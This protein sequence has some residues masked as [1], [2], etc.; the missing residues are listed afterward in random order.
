MDIVYPGLLVANIFLIV[1]YR[2]MIHYH[3]HGGGPRAGLGVAVSLPGWC[4]P[5]GPG[6]RYWR[7]YWLAMAAM[8]VL[9]AAGLLWRYPHIAAAFR[10]LG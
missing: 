2:L 5:E 6:G 7:R 10:T 8:A 4:K 9:V 3:Q 1:Y